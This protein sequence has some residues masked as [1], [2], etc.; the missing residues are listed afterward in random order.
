[1]HTRNNCVA[2]TAW[3]ADADAGDS[4]RVLC[5]KPAVAAASVLHSAAFGGFVA[6]DVGPL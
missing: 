6:G 5:S 2:A 4:A 1:M 3:G